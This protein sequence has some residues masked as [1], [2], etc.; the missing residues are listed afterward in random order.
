MHIYDTITNIAK[1]IRFVSLTVS[2]I[3]FRTT[4]T[5]T[6]VTGAGFEPAQALSVP[7]LWAQYLTI[8]L[9]RIKFMREQPNSQSL[10]SYIIGTEKEVIMI[11]TVFVVSLF[12]IEMSKIQTG[13]YAKTFSS[14]SK[15][16]TYDGLSPTA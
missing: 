15:I 10:Y 6:L 5:Q 3:L 4:L 14:R 9:P 1:V 2:L 16:R 8:R 11:S 7:G 13:Q 12:L